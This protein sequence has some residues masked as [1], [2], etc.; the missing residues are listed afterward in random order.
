MG[1][2]RGLL[3]M[4]SAVRS[5]AR[6]RVS[7]CLA[8]A[9]V[10]GAGGV[11]WAAIPSSGTINGCFQKNNGQLRVIDPSST[12]KD[13]NSST[14]RP[15]E[16]P[17]S[18][19]QIGPPG[20]PGPPGPTG[21]PG[22][23][24]PRGPSDAFFNRGP[25]TALTPAPQIM[26]H[27]ALPAGDYVLTASLRATNSSGSISTFFCDLATPNQVAESIA[28][29]LAAHDRDAGAAP[30]AI[31][32]ADSL[33]APGTATLRCAS[34]RGNEQAVR[35]VRLVATQVGTLHTQP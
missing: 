7:A 32:S 14:C 11:A 16:Q 3:F 15:D 21:P 18:W 5:L 27:L 2:G 33:A 29:V 17:I 24:G 9:F 22:E 23:P 1:E 20:A 19:N 28:D 6:S 35:E 10:V 34:I 30:M 25:D 13:P 8:G 12:S 4:T 26:A 31:D